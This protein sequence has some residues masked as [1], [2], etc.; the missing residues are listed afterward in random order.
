[1]ATDHEINS[2]DLA[3]FAYDKKEEYGVTHERN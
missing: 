2:R 1:M 3:E